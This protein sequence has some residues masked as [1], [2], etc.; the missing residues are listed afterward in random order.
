MA[1]GIKLR[2]VAETLNNIHIIIC[3]LLVPV[4]RAAVE[5]SRSAV[6]NDIVFFFFIDLRTRLGT[7]YSGETF[8]VAFLSFQAFWDDPVS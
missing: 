3:F 1:S 6:K 5:P 4:L 8:M 7:W 2:Q